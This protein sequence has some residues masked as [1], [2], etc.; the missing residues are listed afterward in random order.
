MFRAG[1]DYVRI[2]K[3]VPLTTLSF[4]QAIF[5]T[6]ATKEQKKKTQ[7]AQKT[8]LNVGISNSSKN[9]WIIVVSKFTIRPKKTIS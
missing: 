7:L 6:I 8:S 3:K 2:S 4:S 9:K 1:C 5:L